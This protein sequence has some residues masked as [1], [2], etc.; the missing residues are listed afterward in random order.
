MVKIDQIQKEHLIKNPANR[1]L[2]AFFGMVITYPKNATFA[3][4][5]E[6]EHIVMIIRRHFIKNVN[7][8]LNAALIT[9]APTIIIFL[10]V[11]IDN[12]F[13]N[14]EISQSSF[15]V[16]FDP[17]LANAFLFFYYTVCV[18][19]F[20]L[21]FLHWYYDLFLVT[22]ERFISIDFDIVKGKIITDIPLQ[23]IIDISEKVQG[24]FP[25]MFGYGIIEF[26]TISE[27]F[28]SIDGVA[29]TTW[30][31]D[32]L[33]DLIAF[34][35]RQDSADD[36]FNVMPNR[37]ESKLVEAVENIGDQLSEMAEIPN[38]EPQAASQ[39]T[40]QEQPLEVTHEPVRETKYVEP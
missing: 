24:F 32:S 26:K 9:A 21:N 16:D 38:E 3:T 29:Q 40:T 12:A 30:F 23:D 39:E 4:Q 5:N 35:R 22:N 1:A 37:T 25:N 19:F 33:G 28:M 31:R 36:P 13:F 18:S 14:S 6:N 2:F 34:I 20:L 17:S 8:L 27:K 10:F 7:W 11:I 15:L